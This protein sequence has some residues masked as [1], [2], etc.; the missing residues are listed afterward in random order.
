MARRRARLAVLAACVVA[1]TAGGCGDESGGDDRAQI[2]AVIAHAQTAFARGDL[3]AVCEALTD[4]GR[5][6]VGGIGHD[7]L[8]DGPTTPC[9]Q[10]L[11]VFYK[12]VKGGEG[13]GNAGR[14]KRIEVAGDTATAT[15]IV[16]G[17]SIA[18]PLAREDGD[19]KVDALWGGI[20]GAQQRDHY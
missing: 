19:W 18:V 13:L 6:H 15:L 2:R 3:R 5:R 8:G 20:P 17:S 16:D 14:V 11:P 4:A 9:P 7:I 10:D 1:A 12:S